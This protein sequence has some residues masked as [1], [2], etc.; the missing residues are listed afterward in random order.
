MVMRESTTWWQRGLAA[1]LVTTLGAVGCTEPTAHDV[2]DWSGDGGVDETYDAGEWSEDEL[3]HVGDEEGDEEGVGVASEAILNGSA[4]SIE[5]AVVQ[6][7]HRRSSGATM[8]CTGTLI[9]PDVVLTNGH[10]IGDTPMAARSGWVSLPSASGDITIRVGR[11]GSAPTFTTSTRW[12]THPPSAPDGSGHDDVALIGLTTPVPSAHA[13]WLRVASSAP[14]TTPIAFQSTTV[15]TAIG[16][17]EFYAGRATGRVSGTMTNL[18][19]P[20]ASQ[21]NMRIGTWTPGV[22]P[23]VGGD[24]GSP[25]LVSVPGSNIPGPAGPLVIGVMGNGSCGGAGYLSTM[26]T[27][28]AV[29][30]DIASW[31]TRAGTRSFCAQR[32]SMRSA[33]WRHRRLNSW[34]SQ[35]RLDNI[36]TTQSGYE[37][38]YASWTDV[39]YSGGPYGFYRHEGW[40][41]DASAPRPAGVVP[42]YL[43]WN[44]S[45]LD[46]AT[47][48]A[49]M[50]PSSPWARGP[51][52][53]YVWTTSA[54][55]RL[56]LRLWYHPGRQDYLTTTRTTDLS[57]E[58]YV[59]VGGTGIIG[60]VR[61]P[62]ALD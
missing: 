52:L 51:L 43:Y 57:R 48:T 34:W 6:I 20:C 59:R 18:S 19:R 37:G 3:E 62:S 7:S 54:P 35:V 58:G 55:D 41:L 46:N 53:G 10:C 14:G 5:N 25:V 24:S 32:Q 39:V 49:A 16:W 4:E 26:A 9:R 31:L 21:A 50:A 15:G 44:S 22:G 29:K 38:C 56:A 61:S 13:R 36:A 8:L 1:C 42:L 47:S 45:T 28:S 12:I 30:P 17:G 27:G 2:H 33:D 11:V 60:Y 23:Y 40:V